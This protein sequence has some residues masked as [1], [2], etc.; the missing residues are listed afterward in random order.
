MTHPVC[1][2]ATDEDEEDDLLGVLEPYCVQPQ[3][4]RGV[5]LR[6]RSKASI[7]ELIN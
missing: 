7:G 6:K 2:L 1:C 5:A 3:Q 4:Q